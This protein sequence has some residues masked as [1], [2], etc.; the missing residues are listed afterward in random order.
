MEAEESQ[1]APECGGDELHRLG[2]IAARAVLHEAQDVGAGDRG[3]IEWAFSESSGQ[4]LSDVVAVDLARLL[5]RAPI[6]KQVLI[7]ASCHFRERRVVP[8]PHAE[9]PFSPRWAKKEPVLCGDT[10]RGF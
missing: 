9:S 2:L 10:S 5:G 3:K 7:E 8:L 4:E 1:Q 6:G